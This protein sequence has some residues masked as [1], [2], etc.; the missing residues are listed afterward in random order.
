MFLFRLPGSFLLRIAER[1]FL[2]VL[3]QEPPRRTRGWFLRLP[4]SGESEHHPPP[5]R[6]VGA[7]GMGKERD[8]AR[9]QFALADPALDERL[10][11]RRQLAP[12]PPAA[13][14]VQPHPVWINRE[15]QPRHTEVAAIQHAAIFNL[16]SDPTQPLRRAGARG[17]KP[18]VVP[19]KE[20]VVHIAE[21]PRSLAS[22]SHPVIEGIEEKVPKILAGE[23]AGSCGEA[24]TVVPEGKWK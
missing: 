4:Y 21:V 18:G 7:P 17:E 5:L 9:L 6:I 22:L 19:E 20:H 3:F 8:S 23:R 10:L 16:Q 13:L 24:R 2:A 11:Q 14:R 12:E 15:A 1:Q